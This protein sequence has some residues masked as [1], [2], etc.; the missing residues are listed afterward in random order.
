MR[1]TCRRVLV[2]A[3]ISMLAAGC[4]Y[5]LTP[6][7]EQAPV[8]PVNIV[9]V[10]AVDTDDPDAP[11]T[12]RY[13]RRQLIARLQASHA[14]EAVLS[15]APPSLPEGAVVVSGRF[16]QVSEGSEALRFLIGYGAGSPVVRATFQIRDTTGR[17]LVAFK[18]T[19]RSFEGTGYSAHRDPLDMDDVVSVFA[20]RTARTIVRWS[21]G[22]GLDSWFSMIGI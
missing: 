20:R 21:Q 2:T 8:G 6:E 17:V 22:Q 19:G 7:T 3:S 13:F 11:R 10:G 5:W 4:T 14:F 16:T 9:V 15:P 18:E 1:D 12:V